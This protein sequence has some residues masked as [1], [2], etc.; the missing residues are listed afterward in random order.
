MNNNFTYSSCSFINISI[1]THEIHK[2]P[3]GEIGR[4]KGLKSFQLF[5]LQKRYHKAAVNGP[6]DTE[7][8]FLA[9]SEVLY[10]I[11]D[12]FIPS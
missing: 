4:H 5:Y 1:N 2:C 7:P 3:C 11:L 12:W 10:K 6:W 9:A 8:I